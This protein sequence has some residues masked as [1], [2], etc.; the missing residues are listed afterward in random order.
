MK[1]FRRSGNHLPHMLGA[2]TEN[3]V[4]PTFVLHVTPKD[5]RQAVRH[6]NDDTTYGAPLPGAREI[7]VYR[8]LDSRYLLG[9]FYAKLHLLFP[10]KQK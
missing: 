5:L 7:L 6:V 3:E 8:D 9:D 10:A 1:P 4:F 2:S